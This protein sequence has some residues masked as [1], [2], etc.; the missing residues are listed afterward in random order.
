MN[1]ARPPSPP[2]RGAGWVWAQSV[3]MS[4]LVAAGPVAP[5]A[6]HQPAGVLAG[7]L[8]FAGAGVLG[9]VGVWQLGDNRTP[10]PRP[11]PG[12][13]LIEG[14]VY[15]W[16]RLP[17]YVSVLLAGL[18]WAFLWQSLPTLIVACLQLPFFTAKARHEERWLREAFPGYAEY[19]RRVKGFVPGLF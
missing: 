7:T 4:A 11:R 3:L 15:G 1:A 12:S 2:G 10:F 8:L 16:V 5:G 14:G 13:R 18:G 19:A 9:V 17:L 6:W